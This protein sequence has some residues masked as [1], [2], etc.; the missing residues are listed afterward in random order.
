MIFFISLALLNG[1]FI[2]SSRIINGRLGT[3]VGSVQASFWNHL[4]GFICLTLMLVPLG[5]WKANIFVGSPFSS[6]LGGFFGAL[7]VAVN[8][9]VFPRVGATNS[10]LLI[11][12]GQMVSAL[13]VDWGNRNVG[14]TLIQLFGVCVVLIGVYLTRLSAHSKKN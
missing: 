6:Y 4:V 12:S 9:Y 11:I 5:E 3:Q 2:S 14:P 7:F 10:A 13:L 1:A 8:S